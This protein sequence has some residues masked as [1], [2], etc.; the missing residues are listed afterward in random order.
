MSAR[1][2][3][4]KAVP[5]AEETPR[6]ALGDA[7]EDLKGVTLLLRTFVLGEARQMDEDAQDRALMTLADVLDQIVTHGKVL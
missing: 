2:G 7:S 1:G 6:P 5:K 4:L 3:G